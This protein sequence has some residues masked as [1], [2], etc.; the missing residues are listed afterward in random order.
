M[1]E[2]AASAGLRVLV[3]ERREHIAGNAF[4]HRDEHGVLV[5]RY[6]PHIFHTNAPRVS[7]Y[8]SR[9]TEWRPYEH[10]VL[11][12]VDGALVPMPINRTTLNLLRPAAVRRRRGRAYRP[13]AEPC[14]RRGPRATP[15]SRRS[16]PTSTSACSAATPRKQ[17]ALDP[18]ELDAA[19]C[20]RIPVRTNTDDRYFT[21]AFQPMPRDGYTAMFERILDHPLI[22]VAVGVGFADRSVTARARSSG[23]ARSTPI[24]TPPRRAALPQPR[25]S[26]S[27]PTP[28]PE[29]ARCQPVGQI[30]YPSRGRRTTRGSPSSATSRAGASVDVAYEY[31]C[32]EGDRT[33]PS[34][35]RRTGAVRRYQSSPRPSAT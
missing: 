13:V 6:G 3:L 1:A 12:A 11:S 30:N 34:R 24:S 14:E 25:R 29:G 2:R 15:C 31:P 8:L 26:A 23:P 28:T 22:E 20:A 7:E 16:A 10:R 33:I 9:F 32:A 27:R 35:V 17:W 5:H 18:S 19:V 4:D 21:D